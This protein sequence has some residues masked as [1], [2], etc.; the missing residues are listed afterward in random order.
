MSTYLLHKATIVTAEKEAVGSI[1]ISEEKIADVIYAE[2]E[3]H[4]YKIFSIVKK[5]PDIERIEL[6]GKHLMA[7]GIDAHVH[8]RDPGLT[9]KADMETESRAAIAGGVTT[10]FDMPNTRPATISAESFSGKLALAKEKSCMNLGFHFGATNCNIDEIERILNGETSLSP[11]EIKGIKVFM[12][13]STGNMLVDESNALDRLFSIKGKPVLVHCEDE[14]TIRTNLKAAL[15]KHGE[16][17]PFSEHEHI[18]S[19]K[20]CIR[21]S[22]KA[23]EKAI[24][25]GTS[26]VLCHI[27]TL[28][29]IEMVR[30]A[31]TNNPSITAETSCNYLWFSNEDYDR[32][33]S[34]L[35]CN[36][37]VKKP[38]DRAALRMALAD[39]IIDT[40]GSDHAPHLMS[41]KEGTYANAPSGLPSIQQSLP[42]LLTIARQEDVPLTRIASVFSEKASEI[43][44]LDRG[45]IQPGYKA[46]IVIFDIDKEFT[47][48]N[49]DQFS[50][51]GWSPYE[52]EKLNGEI[53]MV[54][55]NGKL[56]Y[57]QGKFL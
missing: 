16:A 57:Q 18:R 33:G 26:M 47:V 22:I 44:G 49:E 29:E 10:A 43:Y 5:F 34:R 55:V 17:I 25:H 4:D 1:V 6:E 32:M 39:G 7:G 12:G 42:V 11:K 2:D 3:G 48:R 56:I 52:G 14:E 45:K 37:S 38:S 21:S 19:R 36:P 27:S 28:E 9:H 20:A 24:K 35:K 8:F 13:S 54:F 15:E 31:K 30:A 50:K 51:C 23:L 41:E 40:I 46:D 53:E